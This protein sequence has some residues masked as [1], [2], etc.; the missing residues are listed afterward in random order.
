V[1]LINKIGFPCEGSRWVQEKNH[2]W[3][4]GGLKDSDNEEEVSVRGD[5]L[6][7]TFHWDN[8]YFTTLKEKT[9]NKEN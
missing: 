8:F 1:A 6:N 2:L 3:K 5:F 7:L 4:F 9:R